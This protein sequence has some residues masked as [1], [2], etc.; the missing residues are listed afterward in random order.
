MLFL[1]SGLAKRQL[2]YWLRW[3][4][5]ISH[6]S[7]NQLYRSCPKW[8]LISEIIWFLH[9]SVPSIVYKCVSV[10]VFVCTV[11]SISPYKPS[12]THYTRSASPEPSSL[13]VY[14][15]GCTVKI[16][17][18]TTRKQKLPYWTLFYSPKHA[19]VY[20]SRN[21]VRCRYNTINF[22]ENAR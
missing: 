8:L 12:T 18:C 21:T 16:P 19:K 22:I 4:I 1:Q 10:F 11:S 6:L 17:F 5:F 14:S 9:T 3:N 13:S 20:C 2:F 15:Y 7:M